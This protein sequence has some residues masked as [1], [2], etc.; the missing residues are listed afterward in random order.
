MCQPID[1][2]NSRNHSMKESYWSKFYLGGEMNDKFFCYEV[3][4]K[5]RFDDNSIDVLMTWKV[6]PTNL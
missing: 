2:E 6:A 3:P 5:F 4:E 1:R